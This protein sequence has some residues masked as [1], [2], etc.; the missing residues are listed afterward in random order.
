M[1]AAA[2]LI[3]VL[4]ELRP[5]DRKTFNAGYEIW[6][7][8][9]AVPPGDRYRILEELEPGAVRNLWKSSMGRCSTWGVGLHER[10]CMGCGAG[11]DY[12]GCGAARGCMG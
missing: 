4:P 7:A 2:G 8:I 1:E 10:G 5:L 6:R 11:R 3:S 12:V 9:A